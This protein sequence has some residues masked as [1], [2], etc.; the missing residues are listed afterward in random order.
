MICIVID[1]LMRVGVPAFSATFLPKHGS[2]AVGVYG[3]EEREN[4]DS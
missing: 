1:T 3:C 2:K 4:Y